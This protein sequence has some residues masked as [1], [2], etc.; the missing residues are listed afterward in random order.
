MLNLKL[1]YNAI[2]QAVLILLIHLCSY[3]RNV[4]ANLHLFFH[5]FTL[6]QDMR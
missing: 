6:S 4:L 2:L 1:L 3:I 5:F